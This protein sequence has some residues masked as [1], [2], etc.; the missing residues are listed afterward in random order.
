VH[1]FKNSCIV[2]KQL[3]NGML[4]EKEKELL[5]PA[6][7]D[8]RDL[9]PL[10]GHPLKIESDSTAADFAAQSGVQQCN[11]LRNEPATLAHQKGFAPS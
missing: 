7:T 3:H 6:D 4:M 1:G 9:F 11:P 10:S 5:L 8:Q 2:E